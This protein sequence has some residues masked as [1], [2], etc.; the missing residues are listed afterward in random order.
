MNHLL[1]ISGKEAFKDLRPRNF[2][3]D[4][5]IRQELVEFLY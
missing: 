1:K 3:Y 4:Q 2:I 5:V